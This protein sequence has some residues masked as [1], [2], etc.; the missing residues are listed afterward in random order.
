MVHNIRG[1]NCICCKAFTHCIDGKCY[2]CLTYEEVGYCFPIHE[3]GS[4]LEQS[5]IEGGETD[6]P[7]P[8]LNGGW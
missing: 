4:M 7:E 1:Q 5:D 6:N 2:D 8:Q 3:H